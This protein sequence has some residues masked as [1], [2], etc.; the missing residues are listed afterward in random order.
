[1]KI[2]VCVHVLMTLAHIATMFIHYSSLDKHSY[3][4]SLVETMLESY[5]ESYSKLIISPQERSYDQ[6]RTSYIHKC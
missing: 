4:E 3:L 2:G 6:Q 1:M 5:A